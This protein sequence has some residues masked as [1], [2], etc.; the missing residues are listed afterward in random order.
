MSACVPLIFLPHANTLHNLLS[1]TTASRPEPGHWVKPPPCGRSSRRTG[2]LRRRRS[3]GP[4]LPGTRPSPGPDLLLLLWAEACSVDT[5]DTGSTPGGGA[6]RWVFNC[7]CHHH[8]TCL[9]LQ[10]LLEP[11][12]D[13]RLTV[14]ESVSL[15]SL[16]TLKHST[17]Q[18]LKSK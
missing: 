2:S 14:H 11:P 8:F 15:V 16:R 5:E 12:P 3:A 1:P 13:R 9:T 10:L 7:K 17:L 4:S 6:N 18:R